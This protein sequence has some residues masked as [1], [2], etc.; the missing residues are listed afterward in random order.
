MLLLMTAKQNLC[1]VKGGWLV[2]VM[3]DGLP[4]LFP[5]SSALICQVSGLLAANWS[6]ETH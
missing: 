4:Q 6:E 5:P 1:L 2:I 3:D